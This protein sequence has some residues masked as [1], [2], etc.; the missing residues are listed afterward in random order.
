MDMHDPRAEGE[1]AMTVFASAQ[2]RATFISAEMINAKTAHS[3]TL[4][5]AE[6]MA[7]QIINA[8]EDEAA[9]ILTSAAQ[10]AQEAYDSGIAALKADQDALLARYQQEISALAMMDALFAAGR[11]TERFDALSPWIDQLVIKAVTRI[12]GAMPTDQ[13]FLGPLKECLREARMDWQMR[14]RVHPQ[15]YALLTRLRADPECEA[16]FKAVADIVEDPLLA[17]G[18]CLLESPEGLIDVSIRA[19]VA[20]LCHELGVS[21]ELAAFSGGGAE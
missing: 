10:K 3:D 14:L 5:N 7:K 20:Q 8:A 6:A 9:H 16:L 4:R 21:R 13:K 18:D 19:Q 1:A 17:P 11:L 2:Y 12:V 15:D